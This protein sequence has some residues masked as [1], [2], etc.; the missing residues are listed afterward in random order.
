[1]IRFARR[2]RLLGA[3]ERG[4]PGAA[5]FPSLPSSLYARAFHARPSARRDARQSGAFAPHSGDDAQPTQDET[6]SRGLGEMQA[7]GGDR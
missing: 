6:S 7:E 2:Q 5:M 1:M 3:A 4:L